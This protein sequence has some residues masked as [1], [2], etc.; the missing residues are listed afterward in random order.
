[1]GEAV[2]DRCGFDSTDPV[3]IAFMTRLGVMPARSCGSFRATPS[4]WTVASPAAALFMVMLQVVVQRGAV[5]FR[6]QSLQH[7]IFAT[8]LGKILPILFAQGTD[9]GVAM[10][11][12]N[13]TGLITVAT[14][15]ALFGSCH[16]A[17]QRGFACARVHDRRGPL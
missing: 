10:L 1:V 8:A 9:F 12:L 11:A 15:E 5:G 2:A 16:V 17:L 3:R 13:S 4:K 6:Q 7:Q 14:V